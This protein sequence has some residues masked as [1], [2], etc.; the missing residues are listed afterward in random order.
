VDGQVNL[1]IS[2]FQGERE[3]VAENRELGTFILK[4]I[5]PMPAGFPKIEIQFAL[6][7]DGMLKV[8]A[9]ELRSGVEQQ[10]DIQ[11]TYGLTDQQVE[12]MLLAGLENAQSDIE[13]RLLQEA[14]NEATQIIY[15]T[16]KFIQ[17]HGK[18]L[19]ELEISETLQ[20]VNELKLALEITDRHAIQQKIEALNEF[21]RPFA[22]RIMDIAVSQALKGNNIS[23]L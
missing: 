17:N 9:K 5:P 15:T 16:E 2:V 7:A 12:E 11:P 21:T 20:F 4:N 18:L 22:E 23:S 3:L 19:N 8:L 10:I 6:N 14:K 13:I 1:K